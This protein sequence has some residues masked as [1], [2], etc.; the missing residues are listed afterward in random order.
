MWNWVSSIRLIHTPTSI[1]MMWMASSRT[2]AGSR[3]RYGRRERVTPRRR[4]V[5][6]CGVPD[7]GAPA[8]RAWPAAVVVAIQVLSIVEG[9]RAGRPPSTA[10]LMDLG[11]CLGQLGL[12]RV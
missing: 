1:G 3:S 7:S 11:L 2:S 10:D 6:G 4:R 5:R 9:G 12:D 8:G